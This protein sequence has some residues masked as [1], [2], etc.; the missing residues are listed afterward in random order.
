MLI[1]AP[2]MRTLTVSYSNDFD[3]DE[4]NTKNNQYGTGNHVIKTLEWHLA[5]KKQNHVPHTTIFN[6]RESI[7]EHNE[8][9]QITHKAMS[10]MSFIATTSAA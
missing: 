4:R 8:I 1:N 3:D 5:M 9:K 6:K 7:D 2:S 10:I